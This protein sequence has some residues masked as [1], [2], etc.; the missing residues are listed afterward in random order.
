MLEECFDLKCLFRCVRCMPLVIA[1][2]TIIAAFITIA[3]VLARKINFHAD[4][5]PLQ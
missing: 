5:E 1:A 4:A 3:A 2:I